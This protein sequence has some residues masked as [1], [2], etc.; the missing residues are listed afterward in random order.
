MT[1]NH[2]SG[3]IY[4]ILLYLLTLEECFK[5]CSF[6]PCFFYIFFLNISCCFLWL[7][8]ILTQLSIS[9]LKLYT[10]LKAD[11][12]YYFNVIFTFFSFPFPP[13]NDNKYF[14]KPKQYSN[15]KIFQMAVHSSLGT[16]IYYS[17]KNTTPLYLLENEKRNYVISRIWEIPREM[18]L[19][20]MRNH[21]EGCHR[22][23]GRL[24]LSAGLRV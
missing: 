3:F 14:R 1:L 15:V 5:I 4:I 11:T 6:W 21:R 9:L 23:P 16:W 12:E 10:N 24:G 19:P 13:W 20:L 17:V 2:F 18:S 8:C 7:W 22:L